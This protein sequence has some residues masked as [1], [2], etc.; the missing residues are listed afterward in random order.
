[1]KQFLLG[2][3]AIDILDCSKRYVGLQLKILRDAAIDNRECSK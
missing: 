2:N 1:M 3:A